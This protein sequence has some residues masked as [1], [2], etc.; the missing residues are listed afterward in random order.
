MV[1]ISSYSAE[2]K[3]AIRFI[4]ASHK[5]HDAID[6]AYFSSKPCTC[7]VYSI[8]TTHQYT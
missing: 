5:Q 8:A 4:I 2:L 1:D 7:V 6:R 3:V